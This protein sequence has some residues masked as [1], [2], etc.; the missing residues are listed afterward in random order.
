MV[1]YFT[2]TGNSLYAA[3][4]LDTDIVSIPQ[5]IRQVHLHYEAESIGIVCP[6]YGHEMPEMVKDFIR[7]AEL[8]SAYLYV[9]LTYGKLHANAVELADE[10]LHAAGKEADYITTVNMVD[11]FLPAF[12]M[13]EQTSQDKLVEAQLAAIKADIQARKQ[14]RQKVTT[15]DRLIHNMYVTSVSHQPATMWADYHI[16]EACIG[17]GLCTKVCPAGCIH[18]EGQ[19]AVYD[20]DMAG[21]QACMACIH[22]CSQYAIQMNIH[23]KNTHARYRNPHVTLTE[24]VDANVQKEDEPCGSFAI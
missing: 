13:E 10:C 17:C 2:G 1:F 21:C 7:R 24:L 20:A 6:M 12:D 19:H 18:L 22:V 3:K 4:T 15:K 23:E 14:G 11:N 9:V 5:I 8:E 16:T